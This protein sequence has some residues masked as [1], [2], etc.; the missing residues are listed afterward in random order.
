MTF[1]RILQTITFTVFIA[2]LYL[3]AFPLISPVP[4][5]LF[6]RMDPLVLVGTIVS[7]RAFVPVLLP[8]VIILGLTLFLGRFF[9]SHICPMG[10]TIDV[11]DQVFH[12]GKG[13]GS[14][15][16]RPVP[17]SW[18]IV[19]YLVLLFILGAALVGVSLVFLAS[20]LSLITRFYGLV[21][22]PVAALILDTGLFVLRGAAEFF[23]LSIL[24]Y[25]AIDAP[26]YALQLVLV[27]MFVVILGCAY[28][29]PRFW[30]RYLC[31]AGALFALCSRRPLVRRM[32]DESCTRC[33][34]CVQKCPMGAILQDPLKTDF[35]E[36][37]VCLRCADIC[38]ERAITFSRPGRG[39]DKASDPFSGQR[40]KVLAS[41]LFGAGTAVV[42]LTGLRQLHTGD[43]NGQIIPPSLIR[44][45][46][47]VP[48]ADFLA[49][50][51]RCG[52]CMKA[53]PT[54]TL[55]PIGFMSGVTAF[56]SP[57][58]TPQRGPCEPLCNVCG[59]VCPTA[60]VRPLSA[61]EKIWAKVG[62]AY[63]I[64]HKCLAWEFDQECLVCDEVCPFDAVKLQ[65][66]A[67]L[68]VAVPF[69]DESRC[70]GCGFCEH[71][72]PIVGDR[73]IVVEPMNALRLA[74]GSYREEAK[75]LGFSFEM[76]QQSGHEPTGRE[77]QDTSQGFEDTLPPGFTE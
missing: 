1:Q 51:V 18:R 53:C 10:T 28:L 3:A 11:A 69:V 73:A 17:V 60:A 27:L 4:V 43:A 35:S 41:G 2:L 5:D 66:V 15:I 62:T 74:A 19:K 24:P 42:S 25:T 68:E 61:S 38:P 23:G 33:N 30:C 63:V 32:V 49:R 52:E 7:A 75:A 58:I 45:P 67:G 40:R 37:I 46:G 57:V 48:E 12:P 44:P 31:P 56:A 76:K 65:R 50:C 71:Y 26:R 13:G 16:Y 9:C 72:C 64:K 47:A 34:L 55:Q 14:D 39:R 29:A 54:N 22:F 59:Q 20:P 70:N 21:I 8:A 36:C 6:L 77:G